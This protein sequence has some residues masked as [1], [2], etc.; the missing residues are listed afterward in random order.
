MNTKRLLR[1]KIIEI[2]RNK[3]IVMIKLMRFLLLFLLLSAPAYAQTASLLPLGK[4]QYFDNNG[5]PLSGGKVYNYIPATTTFKTTWQDSAEGTANANPVVLDA[6]GRALIYGEGNYRQIV[7]KSNG[8]LVWDAV[9]S[10]TGSGGGSS[11]TGDGDLV[12]TVKPWAGIS[13]PNQYAFSYGQELSRTTYSVLM[14]AITQTANVICTSASNTL[15]GLS[16]TLSINVG[17][18]VEVLCMPA[19]TTVVSKTASTVVLSNPATL[20]VNAAAVIFNYGNGDGSTTFNVPDLRGYALAG[21]P[22]MGGTANNVIQVSTTITTTSASPTAT[23]ASASN[24]SIGMYVLS[25]NVPT[26][27]TISNI[28]G[29]TLTLSGNATGSASGTAAT[30]SV[31]QNPNAQ[32]AVGGSQ[33]NVLVTSNLPAYTPAGTIVS[34][35]SGH[36]HPYGSAIQGGPSGGGNLIT[37]VGSANTTQSGTAN[38]TSNFTG[39]AQGG[40]SIAF[41]R[42][43]PTITFNYIIKITPDTN[44]SVATG[45]TDIQGMT[46]SIACGSG[47]TCTGN[48]INSVI[49]LPVSSA[50]ISYT[51]PFSGSVLRTGQ[52]KFSDTISVNDFGGCAGTDDTT[53]I[54]SAMAA[55]P[56]GG[57][58]Y[59]PG[60]LTCRVIG[61][62]TDIFTRTT[63]ITIYGDGPSNSVI[64]VGS[65]VPNTRNVFKFAPTTATAGWVLRDFQIAGQGGTSL[66]KNAI[67]IDTTASGAAAYNFYID[68]MLIL[69]TSN[70]HSIN[71]T[72]TQSS[73]GVY[74]STFSNSNLESIYLANVGDSIAINNNVIS[75]T[76]TNAAIFA[77]NVT[78]AGNLQIVGNNISAVNGHIVFD[79]G[80]A[81]IIRDNEIET[82][83][84]LNNTYGF[85][86][87]IR[88]LNNATAVA[89]T[90]SISTVAGGTLT[91]SAVSSGTLAVGQTIFGTGIT[92]QT[93]ITALGTGTGGTGTYIVNNSQT[94]GSISMT[95]A[96]PVWSPQL[97][98]NQ[99][100]VLAGT[101][102]PV[103]IRFNNSTNGLLKGGRL[104]IITGNHVSIST[105]SVQT[106]I[107]SG[108]QYVTN[109]TIGAKSI[110]NSGANTNIEPIVSAYSTNA[111]VIGGGA[112]AAPFTSNVSTD[113]Q[114]FFGLTGG[115]PLF[116]SVTGDVTFS[117][118]VSAIGVNKVTNTMLRQSV[119]LSLIGRSAN[120]TGN[121]ADIS[122][123]AA[124]DAVLRESGSVVGFGTIATGGIANNAITLAKLA[125][126][127]TNTVLGNA[128]SGTAVPTAL[129]V[130]SCSTASSA[131]IW[132][133]NTGFGCNTSITAAAVPVSGI[134]GLGTGVATALA[135]NIGTAGSF[136]VNGGAL[137]SPS[138]A[139]TLPAYT[140]GGTISGGGN[141]INNVIIGTTTPLAGTFTTLTA[142]A[143]SLTGLTTFALRDTSAAFDVTFAA[144]SSTALSAGRTLT[145]DMKNVA[146]TLAFGSTANT[147]TFPS[148]ASYT[149]AQLNTAQTFTA[150]QTITSN[151]GINVNMSSSGTTFNVFNVQNTGG[152]I[153]FGTE[154]S[155]GGTFT[156]SQAYAGIFGTGNSTAVNI[157]TNNVVRLFLSTTGGL[158]LGTST[159]PGSGAFL[160]N[161][162]ITVGAGSAMTSSGSGGT[163]AS[164]TAA[165]QVITGGETV[166]ALTQ[167]AGNLTINCG[168]RPLQYQTNSGAFT[169]TAPAADSACMLLSTNDGSAGAITFSGFSVGSSTGDALTTTN[170]NKFT[171]SIWRINGVS[172][173][174]V[175]A[176][177]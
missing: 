9:T 109:G 173:Y 90:G 33:S 107:G 75:T 77:Y 38:I 23:V 92:D 37:G 62:G 140:L 44:S 94:I 31:F 170:G 57:A 89:F 175:A 98:S 116:R 8:D 99:I 7:R 133:T 161:T 87:D 105:G 166:T 142:T 58:L 51:A 131:L 169:L 5:N 138:S 114:V 171:I 40:G 135:V 36:T 84:G 19:G 73:G 15:T 50:N 66:G 162:S 21:R 129:A 177:Q 14:T 46:G 176:H 61:S 159:D 154:N 63:P 117:L 22:N 59:I 74:N 141:Q 165:S 28:S 128:T 53:A 160:A 29:T 85:L 130:G 71:V 78:G 96:L 115:T 65:T 168:L 100:Q 27:T 121:V 69:P 16:D 151:A 153:L 20:T 134:T 145:L 79:G 113:D 24:L 167:T 43:Q 4:Q 136:V 174:R 106:T 52:S 120:S 72:N 103:P 164:L 34:T 42:I 18:K 156:G 39:T 101:L 104:S 137:G 108:T 124:S 93:Q 88:G 81:P 76:N 64:Q 10:S 150:V 95:A 102:N 97:L 119:A 60:G 54:T 127:A 82:P 112:G 56:Y 32:Y 70:G 12:G 123:T 6:A 132:T 155:T 48:I 152:N 86:V 146:H 13:A 25:T 30:F 49:T 172:G 144:T 55:V 80:V 147:I 122:T 45:V 110:A 83:T 91:V 41:S 68:R 17:A 157:A 1:Q 149:V 139:G 2:N 163:M 126:Q 11:S 67:Y 143:G 26:G 148:V 111:V 3:V 118:G 47:L 35:D 158:S 125:T